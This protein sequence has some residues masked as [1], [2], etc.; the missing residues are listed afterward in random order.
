MAV[1]AD[2]AAGGAPGETGASSFGGSACVL[3]DKCICT[4]RH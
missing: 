4:N 3:F 1:A 2:G